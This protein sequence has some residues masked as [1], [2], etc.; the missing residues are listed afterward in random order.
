[1][2]GPNT[3]Q[4]EYWGQSESGR[5][6]LTFEDELDANHAP[7][8]DLVLDRSGLAGG[9]NVLDIGCGTGA[10]VLAAA[11]R[12]GASGHVTGL[13][14]SEP[15]LQRARDRADKAGCANASFLLADAQVYDFAPELYDSVISRFGVMFFSDPIA[16]F[17]N[18]ARAMRP[19]AL[20]TFAAW[21]D[22]KQNPWFRTTHAIAAKRLGSPPRMDPHAPGPLAFQDLD[23]VGNLLEA[24]G[25]QM[26][27]GEAVPMDLTPQGS[28]E[29]VV[30]IAAKVGPAARVMA[31]FEATTEDA[32][33]IT[34]DLAAEFSRYQTDMGIRVPALINLVQA[35]KP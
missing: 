29:D 32:E 13:D 10:S 24:A 18:I 9:M 28:L 15:F 8:L 5:K 22:L 7:V 19:G 4:A 35:E 16:A 12:I 30:A 27:V 6:W 2:T 25:L 1:M 21:G 17:A 23:R 26:R 34:R 11:A 14:I 33:A 3:E 20:L 31:H